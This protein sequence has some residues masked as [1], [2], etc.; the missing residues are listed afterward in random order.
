[1]PET[2]QKQSK[3]LI[4]DAVIADD[5][6]SVTLTFK[7]E[8]GTDLVATVD[9]A[10]IATLLERLGDARSKML[11]IVPNNMP[12]GT[13]PLSA[14]DPRWY[15]GPDTENKFTT[16]WLRHPG[17]GWSGYGFSRKEAGNI[18]KWLRKVTSVTSTL[19]TQSPSATSFGADE[20]LITTEGLG[21]YYYGKGDKRIGQ[22]PF[23]QIEFDSDRAAGLVAGAIAERRLEHVLRSRFRFADLNLSQ[24]LFRPSGPLGSFST[25]IDLAHLQGIISAEAYK[26]LVNIKN[27]RNDF[28]HNL[29]LDSFDAQS[30]KDR[31]NNL[32]LIDRYVG[33]TMDATTVPDFEES[34]LYFGLP[35]YEQKRTDPRFRYIMTA[36]I[37]S[38][39]LGEGSD[40]PSKPLPLI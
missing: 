25:K 20:L 11:E 23:E 21:F 9:A 2:E 7:N 29:E 24:Q 36:Q 39:I 8:A 18:S 4:I 16:L 5:K 26:D 30:I 28:A 34:I 22:N 6:R 31:C 1:M 12:E 17:F 3:P 38:F 19:D 35:D 32:V 10:C 13:F 14:F 33:P 37:F 27:I 15:V 40:Y